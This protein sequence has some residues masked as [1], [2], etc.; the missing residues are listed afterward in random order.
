MGSIFEELGSDEQQSSS[1]ARHCP[2]IMTANGNGD[3]AGANCGCGR[4][5]SDKF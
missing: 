3:L 5:G 4:G 1:D 2:D